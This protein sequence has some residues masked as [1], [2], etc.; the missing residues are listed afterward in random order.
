MNNVTCD[1]C[2]RKTKNEKMAYKSPY[3]GLV[4]VCICADCK[5]KKQKTFSKEVIK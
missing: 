2:N 4:R 5:E 3:Y 1:F